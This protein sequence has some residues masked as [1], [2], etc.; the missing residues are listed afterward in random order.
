MVALV[1]ALRQRQAVVGSRTAVSAV[2]GGVFRVD[3]HHLAAVFAG[4]FDQRPF[5]RGDRAV[6]GFA[7]HRRFGQELGPEVFDGDLIKISGYRFGPFAAGISALGRDV[8]VLFG[9]CPLGRLYSHATPLAFDRFAAGHH[10][11]IPP[12]PDRPSTAMLPM[13]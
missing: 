6:G 12:Q 1:G 11:L 8:G 3:Q 5:G 13:R 2:S 4:L 10:P 9:R 7:R